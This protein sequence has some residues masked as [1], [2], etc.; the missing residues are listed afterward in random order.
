LPEVVDGGGVE[1]YMIHFECLEKIPSLG[2]CREEVLC[3]LRSPFR[4]AG[5]LCQCTVCLGGILAV[6]LC[7]GVSV[8]GVDADEVVDVEGMVVRCHCLAPRLSR[9]APLGVAHPRP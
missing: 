6:A 3:A 5:W 8:W 9:L 2:E 4:L 1:G 7:R